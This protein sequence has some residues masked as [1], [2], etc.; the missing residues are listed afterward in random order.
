MSYTITKLGSILKVDYFEDVTLMHTWEFDNTKAMGISNP[1]PF[2]IMI[3]QDFKVCFIRT[4][5]TINVDGGDGFGPIAQTNLAPNIIINTIKRVINEY[6]YPGVPIYSTDGLSVS[7]YSIN[8]LRV[9]LKQIENV[10]I[11]QIANPSQGLLKVNFMYEA[12]NEFGKLLGKVTIGSITNAE[13]TLSNT[14]F[15]DSLTQI[16]EI[17]F[18]IPDPNA[19]EDTS[20]LLGEEISTGTEF[21]IKV[22]ANGVLEWVYFIY[23]P[24]PFAITIGTSS[25]GNELYG[26]TVNNEQPISLMYVS[27]N[28]Q[29]L[30]YIDGLPDGTIIKYKIS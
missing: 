5:E 24:Y 14:H 7:Y 20:I 18:I 21:I 12:Y 28:I 22:P 10:E 30:V 29:T 6:N 8:P 3:T 9:D 11:F 25:A 23:D 1:Q 27:K 2:T 4:V 19:I 15:S 17:V 16:T 13:F 26:D